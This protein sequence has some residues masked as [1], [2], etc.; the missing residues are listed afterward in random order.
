MTLNVLVKNGEFQFQEALEKMDWDTEKFESEFEI[1]AK[2][3]PQKTQDRLLKEYNKFMSQCGWPMEL[4]VVDECDGVKVRIPKVKLKPKQP[5]M[6]QIESVPEIKPETTPEPALAVEV[7]AQVE[8]QKEEISVPVPQTEPVLTPTAELTPEIAPKEQ[9]QTE[10]PEINTS[11]IAE[12]EFSV[13]DANLLKKLFE[14]I[15]RVTGSD[16]PTFKVEQGAL[17]IRQMDPGRTAMIDYKIGKEYFENYHVKTPGKYC[18]DIE[19]VLKVAFGKLKKDTPVT[20]KI[21][22]GIYKV[23]GLF[24]E[25]ITF[26]FH[27]GRARERSFPLL[28]SSRE[29]VP[30]PKI[31]FNVKAKVVAKNWTD[32]LEDL[33]KVSDHMTMTATND[34]LTVKAEGDIARGENSY[35]KGSAELLDLEAREDSKAIYSLNILNDM[36]KIDPAFCDLATVEFTSDMPMRITMQTKFGE[37]YSYLAPRIES[38]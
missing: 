3:Q 30:T 26:V 31:S 25:H 12:A 11:P 5:I 32:D 6:P 8:T 16:D 21:N 29:D 13:S 38:E 4:V 17:C 23:E 33:A 35:P 37:L 9:P 27:E 19:E 10:T 36:L 22:G 34:V 28:E 7:A 20:V 18:F 1:Y 24:K 15:H 14:A 2:T